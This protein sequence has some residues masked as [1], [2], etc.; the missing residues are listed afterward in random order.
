MSPASQHR[1]ITHTV[2]LHY[3]LVIA[4]QLYIVL[5]FQMDIV[6]PRTFG[7]TQVDMQ[8]WW[9][10]LELHFEIEFMTVSQLADY[11]EKTIKVVRSSIKRLEVAGWIERYSF[12][13]K[14]TIWRFWTE[15]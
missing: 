2:F 6:T 12:R 5:G 10:A 8:I 14:G 7:L 9:A 13:G 4:Q 1:S 11:V 3:Q 15:D